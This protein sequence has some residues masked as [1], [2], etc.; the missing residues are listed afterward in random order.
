MAKKPTQIAGPQNPVGL[1]LSNPAPLP[2]V[3]TPEMQNLNPQK[4]AMPKHMARPMKHRV[5]LK[6]KHFIT[7]K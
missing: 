5:K 6:G 3:T 1:A 4:P 2:N 7:G